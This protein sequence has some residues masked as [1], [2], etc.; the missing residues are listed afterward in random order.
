MTPN[1]IE[2]L[3]HCY[4]CPSEHPRIDAPAVQEAITVFLELELIT[5]CSNA[6]IYVT[7][8]KGKAHVKQL[9]NLPLPTMRFV[10][11]NNDVIDFE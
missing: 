1:D 4:C 5:E 11:K 3:L 8:D 10:D 9:C 2:V 6:N 7:T